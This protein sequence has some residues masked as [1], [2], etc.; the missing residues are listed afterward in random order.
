MANESATAFDSKFQFA[1]PEG[2]K[3]FAELPRT[4]YVT[5]SRQ[6][7]GFTASCLQDQADYLRK[8]GE[9]TNPADALKC[10]WDF[11]QQCWSRS[12]DAMKF[13][14]ALRTNLPSVPASS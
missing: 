4:F 14:D 7:L 5:A 12:S 3:S 11:A 10:Q 2:L 1:S 9:C 8:L 13:L 6:A